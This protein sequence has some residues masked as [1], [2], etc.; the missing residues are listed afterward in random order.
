MTTRR[1]QYHLNSIPE[2]EWAIVR[3][4]AGARLAEGLRALI[5]DWAHGRIDPLV[6]PYVPGPRAPHT[7][8]PARQ[9]AGAIN[10]GLSR[11]LMTQTAKRRHEIAKA[12]GLARSR[13]IEERRAAGLPLA[14]RKPKPPATDEATS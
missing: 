10:G 8:S 7:P 4:K 14:P 12:A 6:A 3:A 9:Q 13:Q 2:A 11:G 5:C 1:S